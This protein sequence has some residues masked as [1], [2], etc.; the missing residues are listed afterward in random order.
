MLNSKT[1]LG[2][3]WLSTQCVRRSCAFGGPITKG[4]R[5]G[6]LLRAWNSMLGENLGSD[7]DMEGHTRRQW[8]GMEGVLTW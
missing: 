3:R 5:D 6:S 4:D 2:W 8:P 1:E 7:F